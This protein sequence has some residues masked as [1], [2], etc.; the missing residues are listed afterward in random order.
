MVLTTTLNALRLIGQ[1]LRLAF[2]HSGDLQILVQGDMPKRALIERFREGGSWGL[3]GYVWVG[4]ASFREGI[5]V[6][7]DALQLVVVD[8]IPFPPPNDPLT[9]ARSKLSELQGFSPLIHYL[10]SKAA[11]ALKQGAGRLIRRESDQGVLVVCDTRLISMS[12]GKQLMRAPPPMQRLLYDQKLMD[13]IGSLTK[14]CT[15]VYPQA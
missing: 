5:D 14:I 9:E 13:R 15:M 12:Y 6:P 3:K 2:E 11:M 7:R 8:K 1:S 4:A 10:L